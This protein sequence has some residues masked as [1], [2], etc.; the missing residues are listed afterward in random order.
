M[1]KIDIKEVLL[2]KHNDIHW[3]FKRVLLNNESVIWFSDAGGTTHQVANKL[4]QLLE[5]MYQK[6]KFESV[7]TL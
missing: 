7:E 5:D 1:E 3:L 4:T 6:G 2:L